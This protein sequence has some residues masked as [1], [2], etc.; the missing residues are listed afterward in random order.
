MRRRPRPRRRAGQSWGTAR[1]QADRL[2]G[3]PE[4]DR[5]VPAA[6]NDSQGRL[7]RRPMPPAPRELRARTV[8]HRAVGRGSGPHLAVQRTPR[9]PHGC[10]RRSGQTLAPGPPPWHWPPGTKAAAPTLRDDGAAVSSGAT[11]PW[12]A[13]WGPYSLGCAGQQSVPHQH[14]VGADASAWKGALPLACPSAAHAASRLR[15]QDAVASISCL[16]PLPMPTPISGSRSQH[17]P[18]S[19][20]ATAGSPAPCRP[21]GSCA[22]TTG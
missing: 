11:A 5:Q 14:K 2:G 19:G 8:A 7:A 6:R 21:A 22:S 3:R 13:V 18:R 12:P 17:P 16:R 1:G 4:V 10:P 15:A 20:G 9:T